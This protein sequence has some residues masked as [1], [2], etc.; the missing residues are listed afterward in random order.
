[1]NDIPLRPT[2]WNVPVW[3]EVG[4]YVLGILAVF[5]LLWG[6]RQ[7]FL[8]W[9]RTQEK[10]NDTRPN[11]ARRLLALFR[12]L[13]TQTKLRETEAGTVH[14][15]LSW[16]FFLLL[17]GTVIATVD[18]DVGHYVFGN[19]FLKGSVY[20]AYK[21]VLDMGGLALLIGLLL[22]IKRRWSEKSHLPRDRRFV[23]GYATLIFIVISG[24]V[25][26]ALRLVATQPLWGVFSPVGNALAKTY[27]AMGLTAPSAETL[28]VIIWTVH[29]V[30]ALLFIAAI[31][32]TIYAHL[33]R[34]PR[35]MYL[36]DEKPLVHI[37]PIKD[38][39]EQEQFGISQLSQFNE[40]RRTAL[41]ACVECGRCN[42]ACPAM[43]AGTPLKPRQVVTSLRD[44][45]RALPEGED[46]PVSDFVTSDQLWSCTT[47]GA[48]QRACPSGIPIPEMIVEMRRS[49]AL[50][51][52]RFP[53]GAAEVMENVASVGNP[54]GL[55]PYER[56]DWAEGL[57]VPVAESGVHYDILYWVGCA[58]SYD[59]RTRKVARAMVKILKAAGV[60]FAVMA[61]ERCHGEFGRRLGEEYLFQTAFQE[62]LDNFAQYDFDRILVTCPHC[63]NTLKNEYPELSEDFKYPVVSHTVFIEGLLQAG[64]L[65]GLTP[66]DT[67]NLT[68]HDPCYLARINGIEA[69]PRHVLELTLGTAPKDV[70]K[71]HGAKTLCCGAGGGMMWTDRKG[72]RDPV[73]VIRLK[74]LRETGA[75]GCAVA[76]PHCLTMLDTAK[77]L[78]ESAKDFTIQDIAEIVADR[79]P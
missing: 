36:S 66:A 45:L 17:C 16:G 7:N 39:E 22:G 38:I 20:L 59:R 79:L 72:K 1:M 26:E 53:E 43:R 25:V 47:C 55:D 57:D 27:L 19:Q 33:Y 11:Q 42:N 77:T 4:V 5:A 10:L 48:C 54:W 67:A 52:G 46:R 32:I 28:H 62:N 41:D 37:T 18:W 74:A 23:I 35:Q 76:C 63:F 73:N 49:L 3:G 8:Y 29:G 70:E 31:P 75:S 44:G 34:V 64:K 68:Y 58:A 13:F 65:P 71:E 61:E 69:A 60:N 12:S 51:E 50:E 6:V 9:Q 14:W 78:D 40:A 30:A 2:F 24:F 21:F 56:L 15:I